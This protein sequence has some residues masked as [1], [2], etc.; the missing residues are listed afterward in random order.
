ME[1]EMGCPA[2][3]DDES[4]YEYLCDAGECTCEP[5]KWRARAE[6]AEQQVATLT[7]QLAEQQQVSTKLLDAQGQRYNECIA[8]TEQIARLT[9]ALRKY[10][11]HKEGCPKYP[12]GWNTYQC[13]CGFD[14]ALAAV[15]GEPQR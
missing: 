10:G 12:D 15:R 4:D 6:K 11:S 5:V 8:L 3:A 13:T 9:E 1:H 7:Q 14:A 2:I